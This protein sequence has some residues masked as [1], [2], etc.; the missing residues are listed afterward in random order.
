MIHTKGKVFENNPN[1]FNL[2]NGDLTHEIDFR[3]VYASL[4]GEKMKFEG[5]LIGIKNKALEGLF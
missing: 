2:G 4:L 3:S 1:L 5:K